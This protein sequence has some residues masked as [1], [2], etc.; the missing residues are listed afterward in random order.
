MTVA[1]FATKRIVATTMIIAFMIFSGYSAL[2]NMK[3]ELLPDFNFPFVVIQTKWTG[4]TSEDVDTQITKKIE[5][6]SLNVDGIKNI[7]TTSAFGTSVVV[8]QFNFGTDTDTK[9]VQIQSEID[10]IKNDLPNDADS[11]VL[12]GAGNSAG[13]SSAMALFIV[14]KGADEATLTSFVDETMKPALQRNKGIGNIFVLGGTKREIKVELDPY[15]LKAFNFSPSEIYSKIKAANTITPAGTVTDGGKEFILRVSGEIKT[16]E[17]VEN[18]ILSNDNGQTLKLRDLAGISY[19]TKEKDT[20][21]RVNGKDSI[22]VVIEKSKDGNIVEIA[23]TA[24]KQLEE[25]KPLFPKGASYDL[26]KDNS[27][28]VKDAIANVT[29]S[30]LQALVI[31]AIVL[32]VFLKDI[33]ASIFISLSIPISAM[34]TFFLLSTQGISLNLVSLMGLAL[35]VGSLVD[36]SVVTLDNIFDHMQEY[37]EPSLIAA[38]RGTN[39]VI[40]P[41]IASTM[42]SVCVFLPIVIFNGFIKEVFSGIAFSIMF[43]LGASIIVAMLFIPMVSSRFLNLEKIL[44][45]KEKAKYF[46]IFREKY[47]KVIAVSLENKWKVVTGTIGLF[48][49]TMVILGPRVKT[50]FFPT[51]D[52]KEYSVVAS[53]A[54]GLDLE[55]SYEITKKIEEIVKNDKMTESFYSISRKDAAIV[56]VRIKKDTFKTMDRIR[57]NLKDLPDVNL[58]LSSEETTNANANKDYSFQI[59]GNNADEL[60]RIANFIVGEIKKEKWMKDVKSSTEGGNPQAR[61]EINREKAESY[62]INVTN[63]TTM[64]NMSVLGVAPIEIT[65]GTES[66]DVTLQLEEK[67]RNSLEKILDLEIKAKDGIFVRIGDIAKLIQ[68]EGASAISKYNGAKTVTVGLNLDSSKGFNDAAK[69]I[70]K[71]FK[72]SNPATGYKLATAG[73]ARN[74]QDMGSEMANALGLSVVLIYIVLAIQLESFILPL[75]IMSSLPLSIIGVI[76]GMILTGVQLSMFVMIGIIM[77][78]GMVVN[79]AIVLLDFVASMRQKGIS[80]REALIKSGGSRLRPILMT[81]LTT[82]LGWIPMALALGGGSAGYY[83]GMAIAVMFGLSFSTLLTLI[84]IPVVYLIVEENKEKRIEKRKLKQKHKL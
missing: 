10:K 67:Y 19:G 42:T 71:A 58:T 76:V 39:E 37:R 80:I 3:Q 68:V 61:L 25:M 4:A 30:G 32:L 41:M 9:K 77:L 54:T 70:D 55:K 49:F 66:L 84:F 64:L 18:I 75:L 40:M 26:I 60:N 69:F 56:N 8:V 46:N 63:L 38:V 48:I 23:N 11:P 52:N 5:E 2:K 35:A 20:Y 43:A 57:Q 79:N 82:V 28:D 12:S 13:V 27:I 44:L 74:Q 24:K 31:A 15:K 1:E 62:G 73:N 14:L 78:M 17:Q 22:A 16:L 6:A 33:R 81:T 51:I 21:T 65:E 7:T 83:Q 29:S 45:N 72:K 59:E 47:E 50:S 53:L 34:F 36:N